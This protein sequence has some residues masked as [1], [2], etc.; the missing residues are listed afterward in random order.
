MLIFDYLPWLIS[1]A[2][3]FILVARAETPLDK[4]PLFVVLGVLIALVVAIAG[5]FVAGMVLMNLYPLVGIP[6]FGWP[7]PKGTP[8]YIY[9]N[10]LFYFV[11]NIGLTYWILRQLRPFFLRPRNEP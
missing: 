5:V 3:P 11:F 7:R 4:R 8:L 2:L 1:A 10:Q 6:V 9:L